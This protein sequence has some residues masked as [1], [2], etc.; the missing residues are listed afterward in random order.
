MKKKNLLLLMISMILFGCNNNNDESN[1]DSFNESSLISESSSEEE[2]IDYYTRVNSSYDVV[3]LYGVVNETFD[4]RRIDSSRLK[5][6]KLTYE[7]SS[8]GIEIVNGILKMNQAGIY[9][10]NAKENGSK[11]FSICLNVSENEDARY[12]YP[13][14]IDLTNYKQRSGFS[15]DVLINDDKSI[16]L[17][18]TGSTWSRITYSLNEK[19]STNYT[20]ECD[21][22]FLNAA[23]NTRWMGV[24]FHSKNK[25]PYYQFDF[26]KNTALN[27]SI[28]V[29]YVTAESSYSY[30]YVGKWDDTSLGVLNENDVVHVKLSVSNT[31]FTGKLS[32]NGVESVVEATL[33][34]IA[35]GDFGFQCA[36]CMV[37]ISNIKLS[38]DE[39]TKKLSYANKEKTRID[40]DDAGI[41]ETMPFTIASGK[42]VDEIFGVDEYGQQFFAKVENDKLY[43][44]TGELME[45]NLNELLLDLS[46]I[47]IPNIQVEDER[48]LNDV[49]EICNSYG[50]IDLA[51]WSSN[52]DV[53]D[54][55]KE[56]MPYTRLCYIPSNVSSFETYDEIGSICK[57]AGKH[58]A[59]MVLIDSNLLSKESIIKATALGYSIVANAKDGSDFSLIQS[60]LTGVKLIAATYNKNVQNQT[61]TLYD[62]DIFNVD[63]SS[64]MV[65]NHVHS[66][67]SVPLATGHRGAG[68]NN[69]NPDVKLPENTIESFKWAFDQG[70]IAIELDVHM[71]SDNKL[72]VIHD[73]TTAAY[74]NTNLTV[75]NSTLLQLQSIPLLV[76]STYSYDYHIP[77]LN[78]VFAYFSTDEYKDKAIVIEVKDNLY[79]TGVA[80]I[81]LAKEKGWYNRISMIT[82]SETTAKQLKDYD[83]GI[84]VGYLNTVYRRNND[85]YWESYNSYLSRG[86]SLASQW[87][88]VSQEALQESNARGQMYWLWTYDYG[89]AAQLLTNIIDGNRAFTVNYIP[90]FSNNKYMLEVDEPL[91]LASN[92]TKTLSATSINYKNEKTIET[93]VEIIVLSDNAIAK[94]NQLTRTNSGDIKIVLKHKTTWISGGSKTNFYIYSDVVTI[95]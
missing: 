30:P 7:F 64:S 19:Y 57:E 44:L 95:K 27:N 49:V 22:K 4:L 56:Y 9:N 90:F 46:C 65:Y 11:K 62:E 23:D 26:R 41:D 14:E 87:S 93:D 13:E 16:T 85:E 68:T 63:E 17:S 61:F 5:T 36:G 48:H 69:T 67:L 89:S 50:I 86:V 88:T 55:A 1:V 2:T 18:S 70:A 83:S 42:T 53:L 29:T 72:A 24:V 77:S 71:T 75:K 12:D 32:C 79:T 8:Q 45:V 73:E 52:K 74:S 20:I 37:N 51:I 3:Y 78:E 84:Q 21:V 10:I 59:D 47:Y 15:S 43:T 34:E 25:F 40:M 39:N 94:G 28:E 91:T 76:G 92:E 60:A 38:L 81:E 82:F 80:A 66:L 6:Q 35:S 54:K 33:P 31:S 58:H